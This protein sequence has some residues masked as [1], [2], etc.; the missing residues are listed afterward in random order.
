MIYITSSRCRKQHPLPFPGCLLRKGKEGTAPLALWC[1]SSLAEFLPLASDSAGQH[2]RPAAAA[3][4]KDHDEPGNSRPILLTQGELVYSSTSAN[5]LNDPEHFDHVYNNVITIRQSGVSLILR[6]LPP[7]MKRH[8]VFV[9]G[10]S[11]GAVVLSSY[12]DEMYSE[13]IRG[14]ILCSYSCEQKCGGRGLELLHPP[15]QCSPHPLGRLPESPLPSPWLPPRLTSSAPP[16]TGTTIALR[17]LASLVRHRSLLSTSWVTWMSILAIKT[18]LPQLSLA[19]ETTQR[20]PATPLMPW[21]LLAWSGGWSP[22]WKEESTPSPGPT[23]ISYGR[24]VWHLLALSP[25]SCRPCSRA[26]RRVC[27]WARAVLAQPSRVRT[28]QLLSDFLERPQYTTRQ[29]PYLWSHVRGLQ[30]IPSDCYWLLRHPHI[31]PRAS[32]WHS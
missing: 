13:I 21:L 29:I 17:T 15:Q 24:L 8:G 25:A 12:H 1:V 22:T 32:L 4:C 3:P 16:A 7:F 30:V 20:Y 6:R 19:A 28:L 18:V 26:L 10:M 31:T 11:E 9:F 5:V 14:R 23:T 2:G 27:R